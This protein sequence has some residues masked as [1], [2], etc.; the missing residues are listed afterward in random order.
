MQTTKGL[1]PLS[2]EY[3]FINRQNWG[4]QMSEWQ[5]IAL[6]MDGTLLDSCG[7][8]S[9]ENQKWLQIARNAGIQVT[10]ATGRPKR[11]VTPF[12]EFLGLHTPYVTANGSEVW[13]VDGQLL[14]RHTLSV[15]QVHF[16]HDLAQEFGIRFFFSVADVDIKAGILPQ[17]VESYEWLK[18]GYRIDEQRL[19]TDIWNRLQEHGGFEITSSGPN[20]IEINPKGVSKATG[21][22]K[23]C[24][25]LGFKPCRVVTIGDGLNDIKMLQW[26]GL[27]I[28]MGNAEEVV[29]ERAGYVT[30]RN[31]EHGVASAIKFLLH[32]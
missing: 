8:V 25:Y 11:H 6:D 23:V 24:D 7:S 22:S 13:T 2:F 30:G 12:V 27:G 17:H 10:I 29:K 1:L 26:A 32:L 21:L 20:N 31:E 3:N 9:E 4:D 28:A 19:M 18:F 15:E 16:L 5:L 14:E